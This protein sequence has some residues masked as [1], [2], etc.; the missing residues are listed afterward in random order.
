MKNGFSMSQCD[1]QLK[2]NH[3]YEIVFICVPNL[4]L[5]DSYQEILIRPPLA[6]IKFKYN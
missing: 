3:I 4:T 2:Y 1:I 6:T 5:Q